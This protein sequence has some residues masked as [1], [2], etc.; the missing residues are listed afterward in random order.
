MYNIQESYTL[1]SKKMLFNKFVKVFFLIKFINE[2]SGNA[3]LLRVAQL[4]G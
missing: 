3:A 2:K 4:M 1:M